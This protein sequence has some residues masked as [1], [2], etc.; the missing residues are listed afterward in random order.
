M[1]EMGVADGGDDGAN[2]FSE[3]HGRYLGFG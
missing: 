3:D 2:N 1:L